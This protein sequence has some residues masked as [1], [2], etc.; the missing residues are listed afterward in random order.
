MKRDK[1]ALI[2]Q[3]LLSFIDFGRLK[4]E[5]SRIFVSKLTCESQ[6]SAILK[7]FPANLRPIFDF[8]RF[9]EYL[10]ER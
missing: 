9:N 4:K 2:E 6:N 7:N 8:H 10:N 3:P 5:V 1:I